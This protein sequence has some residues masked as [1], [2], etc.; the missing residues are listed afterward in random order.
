MAYKDPQ[1]GQEIQSF[2]ADLSVLERA[3]VVYH[4]MEGW[5]QSTEHTQRYEDL[6]Q[7]ARAYVE[8]IEQYV[9]VKV[10]W[11]GTGPRRDDMIFRV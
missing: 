7:R 11:I 2:P 9:G 1:T 8:F 6:P 5:R 10:G 4:E 3:E